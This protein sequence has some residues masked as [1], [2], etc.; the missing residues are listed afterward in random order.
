MLPPVLA[1]G[2]LS[3]LG[4][5]RFERLLG[6][7]TC[8]FCSSAAHKLIIAGGSLLFATSLLL[9]IASSVGEFFFV[10]VLLCVLIP[11]WGTTGSV[12]LAK[13]GHKTQAP[14]TRSKTEAAAPHKSQPSSPNGTLGG[15][16]GSN[17]GV[18]H[19][20]SP[21][22]RLSRK[23]SEERRYT[24]VPPLNISFRG[25]G[26]VLPSGVCV[27]KGVTGHFDSG[28]VSAI[29]G[30]SGAGK[31]TLLN[32][33]AGKATY[34]RMIGSIFLNEVE[35]SVK[36]YSPVVGFVP[37][38]DIMIRELTVCE[39]LEYY[40]TMRLPP[41]TTTAHIRQVV[42]DTIEV[43]GL[44]HVQRSAIGDETTRGISGGQ[45]KRVNVGMEMVSQPSLLF[46]DEPTSGLDSTTSYDLVRALQVQLTLIKKRLA[47]I[48]LHSPVRC[49]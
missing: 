11:I 40:A 41:G 29:M 23:D 31:T 5:I 17:D 14:A 43:L 18:V 33:L 3:C 34:G 24:S 2:L 9:L 44:V 16:D 7:V 13:R 30:P 19:Q 36:E 22:P 15:L 47:F 20:Q 37:Q 12:C 26:L 39:N 21:S 46:L 4:L 45:R 38:D 10:V 35:G 48:V 25:L 32:V 8:C 27:L 28:C 49:R 42:D 6:A 1:I